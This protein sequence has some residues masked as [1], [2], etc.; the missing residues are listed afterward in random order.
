MK[1]VN[2]KIKPKIPLKK[3]LK[4]I[5]SVNFIENC[6]NTQIC[7]HSSMKYYHIFLRDYLYLGTWRAKW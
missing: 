3:K 2:L 7:Q 1:K 5:K 6:S 4:C